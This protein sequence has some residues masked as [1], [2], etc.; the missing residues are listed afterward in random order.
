MRLN[1]KIH[2]KA[3]YKTLHKIFYTTHRVKEVVGINFSERLVN[4]EH[5]LDF[6]N[7]QS[8]TVTSTDP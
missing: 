8:Q 2:L 3:F 1:E 4:S 7:D 5:N 6:P